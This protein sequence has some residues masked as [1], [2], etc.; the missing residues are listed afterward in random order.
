MATDIFTIRFGINKCYL[1]KDKGVI[2]IDGGPPN[3]VERFRDFLREKSIAP[4]DISLIILT[5]GDFDHVGSAQDIK[6]LTGAKVAIHKEDGSNFEKSRHNFPLG[7][8]HWGRFL[9]F[10]LNPATKLFSFPG[11]TA[12]IILGDTD[13]PLYNYGIRGNIVYTPGH[14]KGSVSVI[15]ETGEAFVGCMAHNNL[16]F[17][18]RPGLP[19]FAEDI[20]GVK[21]SWNLLLRRGVKIIYPAHGNPFPVEAI[22][23]I[24]N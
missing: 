11:G 21:E 8:T 6:L 5:H 23:S 13:Y 19:I 14:T 9:R 4:K 12:D 10:V 2:M 24:L 17:R 7:T 16:P 15:L 1:I 20:H 18:L 3:K 22:K